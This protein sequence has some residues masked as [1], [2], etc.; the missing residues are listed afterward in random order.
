MFRTSVLLLALLLSS[1]ALWQALVSGSMPLQTAL[2]RFLIG[3][4]VAAVML[5]AFRAA[6]GATKRRRPIARSAALDGSV[7]GELNGSQLS[8]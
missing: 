1:P 8:S 5:Y 7:D 6:T 4:P 2:I 3:I